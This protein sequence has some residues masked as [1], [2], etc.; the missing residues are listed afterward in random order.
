MAEFIEKH[1]TPFATMKITQTIVFLLLFLSGA[2]AFSARVNENTAQTVALN[3]LKNL[4]GGTTNSPLSLVYAGKSETQP[5]YYV[6]GNETGFVIVA[7]D[8]RIEPILGYSNKGRPF[9]VPKASDTITGNNFWGWMDTYARQIR[10]AIDQNLPATAHIAAQ[11]ANLLAGQ[12]VRRTTTVVPPLLTTTWGQ[13]WPYNSMCPVDPSGPGGHVWVG[14]VGTAMA[15]ILKFWSSPAVGL[16]SFSY[17]S[18]GYPTTSADFNTPYDWANMPNSTATVNTNI[19]KIMYHTAVSAMSQWGAGGTS[20]MYSSDEDPMTRG[21]KN[22][23]KMASSTMRY[24]KMSNYSSTQWDNL[25]QTELIAGRPIYYRGDG[26]FGHAWVCDGVDNS[27]MYHFNFGWDG[28]YN[29]YYSL[30]NINPGGNTLTSNQHAILGIKPNDG[31]TLTTNTTWSGTMNLTTNIWVPDSLTLTINPGA[32]IKFAPGCGLY[33]SGRL[34]SD[35]TS[36]YIKLTAADTTDGWD[37]VHFDNDYN[38][39]LVMANNDT[40]KMFY[41]QVEYSHSNGIS[42]VAYGKLILNNCKINNNHGMWGAGISVW[43]IPI[44]ISYCEVYNNHAASQGGGLFVTTTNT[45]SSTIDHNNL[46]DNSAIAGGGFYFMN[47]NNVAFAWNISH[48]NYGGNGAGGAIMYGTISLI[49]NKICNNTTPISGGQGALYLEN[50]SGN[51]IDV[52]VANNSAY[53]VFCIN[54]SPNIVNNTIV[55][56][57]G[58]FGSGL[59]V[60]SN[61]DP[62]IKNCIIYGNMPNNL[63]YGNQITIGDPNSTPFFDHCDIQDGLAGIGGPGSSTYPSGNYTNNIYLLP[64]FVS[65][66]AGAGTGYDGLNANWQ[67]QSTSPCINAGDPT[68]IST[69]LPSIDLAGNPRINGAIDMGAYEYMAPVPLQV[70]VNNVTLGSGNYTCYNATQTIVVA[71]NGTAFEVQAGGSAEMIAGQMISY[72]PGTTV[73]ESGYMHGCIAPFGPWCSAPA[74]PLATTTSNEEDGIKSPTISEGILLFPNPTTGEFTLSLASSS[75][76][77]VAKVSIYGLPGE[78]ILET[79][80]ETGTSRMFSLA[81]RASGVY[82]IRVETGSETIRGKIV[83]L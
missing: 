67:V 4:D 37:G 18:G 12:P 63:I 77:G 8:D 46:H 32:I 42:C 45:L 72:L 17:Q 48:H 35:G 29:G 2:P 64:Q 57:N 34:L 83:K 58:N 75:A 23:F 66:S 24:L 6:F 80:M 9:L 79:T 51:V 65:P 50:Y 62:Y 15:Q 26:S 78:K 1:I 16:G 69:V 19:S 13:G 28:T 61:S 7:A 22:Y 21:F 43:Y 20:V 60:N 3:F 38:A 41:T 5:L 47:V 11:W 71:G 30:G 49:N 25:L 27:N 73:E 55:N 33:V 39:R 14:C 31:S 56:N 10:Y 52:L 36:S 70:S 68:G 76:P 82:Y 53:G 44:N 74:R 40:S 54:S 81:G 59:F